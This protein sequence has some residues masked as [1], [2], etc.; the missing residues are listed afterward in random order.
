MGTP[1]NVE[2]R[3]FLKRPAVFSKT[4]KF[5]TFLELPTLQLTDSQ[6]R[7]RGQ[8]RSP[9]SVLPKIKCHEVTGSLHI[10]EVWLQRATLRPEKRNVRNTLENQRETPCAPSLSQ[11]PWRFS[12][13]GDSTPHWRCIAMPGTPTSSPAPYSESH[14]SHCWRMHRK[15]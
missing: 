14:S 1:E 13:I 11:A 8:R 2:I 7:R 5:I 12:T 3:V 9:F 4:W 15:R 10:A 6:G